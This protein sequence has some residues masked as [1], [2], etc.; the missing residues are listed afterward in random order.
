M[1]VSD[2]WMVQ[3]SCVV[4]HTSYCVRFNQ[5]DQWIISF[6]LQALGYIHT[7][8]N[9]HVFFFLHVQWIYASTKWEKLFRTGLAFQFLH[10]FAHSHMHTAWVKFF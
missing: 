1:W 5:T 9:Q 3:G 10:A 6:L 2:L 8:S 7:S 4:M